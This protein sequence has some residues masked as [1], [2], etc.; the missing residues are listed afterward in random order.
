M[1]KIVAI[2]EGQTEEHFIRKTYP[3]ALILRPFTNGR[4]VDLALIARKIA[5]PLARIGM[6]FDDFIILIDRE[7]RTM[8][9]AEL[10][11]RLRSELEKLEPMRQFSIGVPD[12]HIENWILADETEMRRRYG[13]TFTYEGDGT[14]A[15]G[16]L[17]ALSGISHS[18]L[19]KAELLKACSADEI[20]NKSPSF[21]CFRTRVRCDWVWLKGKAA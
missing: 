6:G 8:S 18:P 12:I 7:R 19:E 3:S 17:R 16:A 13:E 11:E 21:E 14:P 4:D 20:A 10:E 2:V 15:K 5:A 1:P 9:A